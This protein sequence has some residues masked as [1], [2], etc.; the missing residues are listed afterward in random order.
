MCLVEML[1]LP[2]RTIHSVTSRSETGLYSTVKGKAGIGVHY[3]GAIVINDIG[4]KANLCDSLY[5]KVP[6]KGK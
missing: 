5:N 2:E 4:E 1:P 3:G 6:L